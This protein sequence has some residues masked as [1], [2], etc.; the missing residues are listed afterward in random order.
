M[1]LMHPFL[2]Q[3]S[4]RFDQLQTRDQILNAICDLEDLFESLSDVEQETVTGLID[5]LN[6]RLERSDA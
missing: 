3:L 1:P 2:V 6:R 5:E 4:G